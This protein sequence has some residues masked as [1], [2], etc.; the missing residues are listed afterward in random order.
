MKNSQSQSL[1]LWRQVGGVAV[2]QGAITLCWLLYRL[3]L[4]QLLAGF[5]FAGFDRAIAIIEDALAVAIEPAAGWLSDS[6]RRWMGTR[7]PLIVAGTILSSVLF[8]AI[9]AI[10]IFGNSIS[11][12]RWILPAVLVAWALA[13]ALFRSPAVSLLG[14]YAMTKQLPQAMSL[15][16]FVGGLAGAIR[17]VAGD[18]ILSLGP[19]FTFTIGSLVL[20]A[21]VAVLRAVNPDAAVPKS[22][23]DLGIS[24]RVS[25]WALG[26]IAATGASVAWGT[27]ALLERI[28]PVVLETQI[29]GANVKLLML[30]VGILMA[31]AALPA[32]II[33]VRAGNQRVLLG[34]LLATAVLLLVMALTQG[35]LVGA[36]VLA[37]IFSY[38]LVANGTIPFALSLVPP[39]RGGFG[40]GV[41]FGGFSLAMSLYSV[42]FGEPLAIPVVKVAILGAIAFL[43]AAGC[44]A[45][46]DRIQSQPP[47]TN[48]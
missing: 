40:V 44:V 36:I 41:Y 34:G 18:F 9:P 21:A 17:P 27:R 35:V 11:S 2:L 43:A 23:L 3:Y 28:L 13:M 10:F 15:L 5:G 6:Q 32:G 38:S 31:F 1:I 25:I 42:V 39:Q 48:S 26:L 4:P 19:A 33:A 20:L 16:V 37:A 45:A 46:G 30:G 22:P 8:I 14:D 47:V 12:L 24:E 29:A 7:L